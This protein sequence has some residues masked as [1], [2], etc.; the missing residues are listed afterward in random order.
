MERK[1]R[2]EGGHWVEGKKPAEV[3]RFTPGGGHRVLEHP[4]TPKEMVAAFIKSNCP[5]AF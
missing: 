1:H 2:C 4:P 3:K 5:L